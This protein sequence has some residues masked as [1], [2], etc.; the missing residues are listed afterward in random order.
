M[1]SNKWSFLYFFRFFGFSLIN[2]N[3]TIKVQK[4]F[5]AVSGLW[6]T[7]AIILLFQMS[8][9]STDNLFIFSKPTTSDIVGIF[10]YV[11]GFFTFFVVWIHAQTVGQSDKEFLIRMERI[12]EILLMKFGQKLDYAKIN[13]RINL[14]IYVIS[15]V[16][17]IG[18]II[19]IS[20]N[21]GVYFKTTIHLCIINWLTTVRFVQFIIY[22]DLIKFRS[23]YLNLMLKDMVA[24]NTV[25]WKIVWV[26]DTQ[27]NYHSFQS[28]LD[29]INNI[30]YIKKIYSTFFECI[31]LAE[32]CFGWALLI[33]LL[34]QFINCT[35]YIY[36]LFLELLKIDQNSY[37]V[38]GKLYSKIVI[39]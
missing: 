38:S 39:L 17:L 31:K 36:W 22:V 14:K 8:L 5:Y 33:V 6:L 18:S 15:F 1:S 11:M 26:Q 37:S 29:D 9:S 2:F 20:N 32:D 7:L 35:C 34:L 28:K 24:R 23:K 27:N 21:Y 3:K 30:L 12:D 13:R 16:F 25:Q 19:N 10:S 4:Y